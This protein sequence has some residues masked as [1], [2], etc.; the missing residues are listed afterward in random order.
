MK[1]ELTLDVAIPAIEC[2][3]VWIIISGRI[4]RGPLEFDGIPVVYVQSRKIDSPAVI[5]VGRVDPR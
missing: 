5:R 2:H 4:S 3:C 1:I